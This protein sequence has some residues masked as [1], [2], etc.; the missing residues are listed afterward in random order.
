MPANYPVVYMMPAPG[1]YAQHPGQYYQPQPW[2]QF[3]QMPGGPPPP[4]G[5]YVIANPYQHPQGYY[6]DQAMGPGFGHPYHGPPQNQQNQGAQKY[7]YKRNS[8]N[9]DHT[10]NPLKGKSHQGPIGAYRHNN[11]DKVKEKHHE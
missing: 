4:G 9:Y 5:A 6:H 1:Q 2:Q 7:N 11:K 10:F 3:Q 8:V